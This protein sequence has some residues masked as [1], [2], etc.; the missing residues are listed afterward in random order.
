MTTIVSI[1]VSEDNYT[2]VEAG[3]DAVGRDV[4]SVCKPYDSD[5]SIKQFN[6]VVRVL[7]LMLELE[8]GIDFTLKKLVARKIRE[9]G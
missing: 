3:A 8:D 1:P 4:L 9:E 2:I 6:K 5:M 7:T